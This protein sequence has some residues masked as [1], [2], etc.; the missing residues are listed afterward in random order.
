MTN[1]RIAHF[2]C[3]MLALSPLLAVCAAET[4]RAMPDCTLTALESGQSSTLRQFRGEVLYVDFW[5]SW[6]GPCAQSFPFMNV[7][8]HDLRDRGLRVIAVNLDENADDARQFL[9]EHPAHFTIA[10]DAGQQCAAAF[11]VQ[12]MPSSYLVDRNGVIRYEH[13]GFRAGEAERFRALAEQL[14]TERPT[15]Q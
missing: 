5:A 8:H 12:A 4:G 11:G 14:L 2:L 15:A 7:L 13:L 3:V 6:C 9:G 10:G 1:K